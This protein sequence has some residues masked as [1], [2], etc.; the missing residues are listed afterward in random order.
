MPT[1][2]E[3]SLIDFIGSCSWFIGIMSGPL[4]LATALQLKCVVIVNFPSAQKIFMP[5]LRV[6]GLVESEWMY[7]QHVHLHQED[8]GPLVPAI[9]AYAL[10]QAFNGE[11]YPFLKTDFCFLIHEPL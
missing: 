7:P 2:D 5:C 9:S 1:P 8:S 6:T 4:H 11:V 10:Q 3:H